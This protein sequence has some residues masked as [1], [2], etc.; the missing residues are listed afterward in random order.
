[1]KQALPDA[2]NTAQIID[3]KAV[4]VWQYCKFVSTVST[5]TT[6]SI[7]AEFQDSNSKNKKTP[8]TPETVVTDS[9]IEQ[10]VCGHCALWHRSGCTFPDAEYTCVTP[11]NI[12][13]IDC[14]EFIERERSQ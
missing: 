9:L 5:V 13:A 14:K 1:M 11:T 3:G 4:K 6:I 12:Y 7:L 8:V 10:H 2:E